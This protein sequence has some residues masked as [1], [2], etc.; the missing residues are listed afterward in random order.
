MQAP[1]PPLLTSS[2]TSA[3]HPQRSNHVA[4]KAASA[5]TAAVAAAVD[6]AAIY[7]HINVADEAETVRG[8]GDG[9][10]ADAIISAED[11]VA[12]GAIRQRDRSKFCGSLPSHLDAE[13]ASN[14]LASAAAP[15]G[16]NV[17]HS[18]AAA[19]PAMQGILDRSI[20]LGNT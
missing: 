9:D 13:D 4:G 14:S 16:S 18:E 6:K 12:V 2:S 10:D 20:T 19:A 17:D 1:Q 5:A 8:H 15:V 7:G 3:H 11:A